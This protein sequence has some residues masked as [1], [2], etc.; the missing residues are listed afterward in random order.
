MHGRRVALTASLILSLFF[1]AR[2]PQAPQP[3]QAAGAALQRRG[4]AVDRLLCLHRS[5]R[6][7]RDLSDPGA[8]R[9]DG[10]RRR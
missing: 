10:H 6:W 7:P 4:G 5:D 3:A 1:A 9:Y 8:E 2:P